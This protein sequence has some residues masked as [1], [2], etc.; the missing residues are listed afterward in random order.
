MKP[1]AKKPTKT[2]A[3]TPQ[4]VLPQLTAAEAMQHPALF[5]PWFG[6]ASFAALRTIVRAIFALPPSESDRERFSELSRRQT[7]PT[8]AATEAWI[9]AGRRSGKSLVSALLAVYLAC[10]RRYDNVLAPGEEG[11]IVLAAKDKAQAR[12][13]M[14]WAKKML[15]IPALRGLVIGS[16]AERISV[17]NGQRVVNIEVMH[18]HFATLRS[19]TV[20]AAIFDEF[21]YWP[22]LDSANPDVETLAAVRPAMATVP[23]A[24]L[25]VIS[26]PYT[27]EGELYRTWQDHY[28]AG[29]EDDPVLVIQAPTTALNPTIDPRVIARDYKRDPQR[30]ASEWG[31]QFRDDVRAWLPYEV[32]RACVNMSRPMDLPPRP[33]VIY[34][35]TWD[36]ALGGRDESALCIAHVEGDK[37]IV[38]LVRSWPGD[39]P[40]SQVHAEAAR[41]VKAYTP[42]ASTPDR[43]PVV[44]G[45]R[46]AGD[47]VVE[48]FEKLGCR[49]VTLKKLTKADAY[50]AAGEQIREGLVE[51]PAEPRTL[52]QFAH[53]TLRWHDGGRASVDDAKRN[54]EDRANVV[55]LGVVLARRHHRVITARDEHQRDVDRL[56]GAQRGPVL[57]GDL[58]ELIAWARRVG[59][60]SIETDIAHIEAGH[61]SEQDIEQFRLDLA[62]RKFRLEHPDQAR[63]MRA[64]LY[65]ELDVDEGGDEE[66]NPFDDGAE[67]R[68]TLIQPDDAM[69]ITVGPVLP[70]TSAPEELSD[71]SQVIPLPPHGTP[72]S[73]GFTFGAAGSWV[74]GET[75]RERV[76]RLGRKTPGRSDAGPRSSPRSPSPA[77]P[78]A[79]SHFAL[80]NGKQV[81]FD[82]DTSLQR[83]HLS[84]CL[85][86][87]QPSILRGRRHEAWRSDEVTVALDRRDGFAL[88][89]TFL[90]FLG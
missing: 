14:R 89:E 6:E 59:V 47:F 86:M 11:T 73:G 25:V 61:C 79:V 83:H 35:H 68:E 1:K 42:R 49:Y 31:G 15:A 39:R 34:T 30:A 77:A 74:S 43:R 65:G 4:P 33:G 51:L 41:I 23:G 24:L 67:D 8:I 44:F 7:W 52:R 57:E 50:V 81:V 58:Q 45:D 72:G 29:H 22:G 13:L 38:D 2:T 85:D 80:S 3:K 71:L 69:A 17:R 82:P 78:R 40:R 27:H 64:G 63:L 84:N 66:E 28:G 21:A 36:Q 88:R 18:G 26:S 87:V 60:N 70:T 90:R 32:I 46:V 9:L 62:E 37:V 55:A 19:Y 48:G 56:H 10:F 12:T 16:T 54:P 5:A 75:L 20:V 76:R 53:L